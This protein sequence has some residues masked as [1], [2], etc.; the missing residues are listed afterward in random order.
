MTPR[1]KY[2]LDIWDMIDEC[3]VN[4]WSGF[5]YCD[6]RYKWIQLEKEGYDVKMRFEI[7]SEEEE[8]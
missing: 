8:E 2:Y 6:M 4:E 5:Q 1:K 7:P 3:W